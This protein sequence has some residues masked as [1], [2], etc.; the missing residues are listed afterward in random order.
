[1]DLAG[2]LGPPIFAATLVACLLSQ[3]F[4]VLHLLLLGVG[5]GL[6]GMHHRHADHRARRDADRR[7]A[8]PGG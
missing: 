5:L 8:A 7:S 2:K 3:E 1:M 6:I 4:D